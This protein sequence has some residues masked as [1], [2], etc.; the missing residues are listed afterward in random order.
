V[1]LSSNDR[2]L[3]ARILANEVDMAFR[4]RALALLDDLELFD[5]ARVLDCGCGM[6][7][8]LMAMEQLRDVEA[9]GLDENVDRLQFAGNLGLRANLVTGDA[10]KLPFADA[11]FDRVLM[12]EVL[13][14]L[15]DDVAALGEA[16]RV[17]CP[18]GILALSVPHARYPFWWDPINA[19]WTAFGG[20]PIRRGPIVGIWTDHERLYEASDLRRLVESA[21]FD[22][23][24]LAG[25]THYTIPFMHFLVYGIGKP[26]VERGLVPSTLRSSVDRFAGREN[27][28]SR[29]NPLNLI[30]SLFRA[31]DRLNDRPASRPGTFV[32]VLVKARKPAA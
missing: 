18:G 24:R 11:A 21:G 6:G 26:L 2:E 8:Y 32:N 14:H 27:T 5:G 31:V 28:G 17:L 12:S 13:E 4:R 3:L 23:E 7:F 10:Q 1:S 30:R 29:A 15:P 25:A 16:F 22:V 19:T 20:R 9:T